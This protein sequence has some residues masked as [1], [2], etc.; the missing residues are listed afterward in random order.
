M[1]VLEF[2][3]SCL[4]CCIW[5]REYQSGGQSAGRRH[6][7][8]YGCCHDQCECDQHLVE[9]GNGDTTCRRAGF[10]TGQQLG[11]GYGYADG[12]GD[13]ANTYSDADAD[14]DAN[15]YSDA[16]VDAYSNAYPDPDAD[17]ATSSDQRRG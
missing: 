17:A 6:G 15:T 16:D 8:L 2:G 12:T 11:D 7:H 9:Y 10:R 13:D 14:A 4:W 3:G 1:D 5:Q